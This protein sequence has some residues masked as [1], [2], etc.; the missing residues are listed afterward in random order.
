MRA[1][2]EVIK[3]W[4]PGS[5][6]VCRCDRKLLHGNRL[7][8]CSTTCAVSSQTSFWLGIPKTDTG[9]CTT[10]GTKP[11]RGF[12]MPSSTDLHSDAA[13]DIQTFR[14]QHPHR[15]GE[16]QLQVL[17]LE[18]LIPWRISL[19]ASP[20]PLLPTPIYVLYCYG[21]TRSEAM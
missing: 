15:C 14:A 18:T 9:L 21:T 19:T 13:A 10:P 11:S 4:W 7:M 3:Y 5:G 6:E 1:P 12:T 16:G 8:P 2:L 17:V 20:C